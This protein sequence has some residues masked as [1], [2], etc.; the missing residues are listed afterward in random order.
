MTASVMPIDD[1]ILFG[2]PEREMPPRVTRADCPNLRAGGCCSTCDFR[3]QCDALLLAADCE[4]SY[5]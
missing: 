3:V 5:G 4:V 1:E 2:V